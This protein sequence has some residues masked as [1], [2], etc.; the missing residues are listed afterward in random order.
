MKAFITGIAGFAGRHLLEHLLACGDKVL[1]SVLSTSDAADGSEELRSR[2]LVE[3]DLADRASPVGAARRTLENFAPDC[4]YHLAAVSVPGQCGDE[5]PTDEA[6]AINVDGTRRVLSFA[7]S[8]PSRP[9]VI[10]ISSSHVYA[11]PRI[12]YRVNETAPLG[13]TTGYGQTK[14]AAEQAA[15]QAV[16]EFEL[17]VIVARAFQHAGPGQ[18][19]PMMLP[20]WVQQFVE[21]D[22]PVRVYNLD[23]SVDVCDV[24]DIVRAYRLLAEQGISAVAYN[25]GSGSRQRTGD[26][27]TILHEM[28][29]PNRAVM[30]SRPGATHNLIADAARLSAQTGWR[31]QIPIVRTVSDTFAFWQNGMSARI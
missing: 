5:K 4:I 27:F 14:L 23:T 22:G 1:G 20:Q 21:G 18:R 9:R 29:E 2:A 15:W 11:P 28:V 6:W 19:G 25:V 30:E 10:V 24:R 12:G 3:W 13:P 17:E 26:I 8:L 7:A 16:R 31:P